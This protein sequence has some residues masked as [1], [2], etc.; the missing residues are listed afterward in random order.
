MK[1]RGFLRLEYSYSQIPTRTIFSLHDKVM[2][3]QAYH[4]TLHLIALFYINLSDKNV[5]FTTV[6]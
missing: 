3:L 4:L 1:D 5:H 6:P 2:H